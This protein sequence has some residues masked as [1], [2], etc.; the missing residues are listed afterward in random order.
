MI[1]DPSEISITPEQLRVIAKL[2]SGTYSFAEMCSLLKLRKDRDF[3]HSDLSGIDF[4]KADL[5]GF[6]FTGADLRDSFG[7]SAEW[8]NST[9][10]LGSN[11]TG[12][13]FEYPLS[14]KKY[15]SRSTVEAEYLSL[16][17]S[18]WAQQITSMYTLRKDPT[19]IEKTQQ[20]CKRLFFETT[21]A[22]VRSDMLRI[23]EF[24]GMTKTDYI[25]YLLYI[26]C[27]AND[28][29]VVLS[30]ARV[31]AHRFRNFHSV[32]RFLNVLRGHSSDHI[33]ETAFEGIFHSVHFSETKPEIASVIGSETNALIRRMY[34]S[35]IFPCV[36][37]GNIVAL[38]DQKGS[39][40]LDFGD[41]IPKHYILRQSD[42]NLKTPTAILRIVAAL[43]EAGI[44]Y[45]MQDPDL[46]SAVLNLR[47]QLRFDGQPGNSVQ[48]K[49]L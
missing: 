3:R 33:R 45:R 21:D 32:F 14:R 39:Q 22:V 2:E 42:R 36:P 4:T 16:K 34:V 44:P 11:L 20:F 49:S 41:P 17:R 19:S 12:S 30:A 27:S 29:R 38:I 10:F 25:A 13:M 35:V 24:A 6:D 46:E 26:C 1:A 15:F 5:R 9:I 47:L 37:D 7:I 40:I 48:V 43:I 18:D 31:L 23:I 28:F 8:D